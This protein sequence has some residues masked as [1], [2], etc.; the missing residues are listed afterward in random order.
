MQEF[1]AINRIKEL[2]QVRSW[3]YY[4]LAKESGIAYSTLNSMLSKTTSPSI[5]TLER[6]CDGFGI[7]LSQFFSD[8]DDS[9]F[10]SS[11]TKSHLALWEQLDE[12]SKELGTAYISGLLDLQQKIKNE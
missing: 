9:V 4:R 8:H 10:L 5:P 3:T 7:T 1:S 6:I 12:R 11:D 2:C